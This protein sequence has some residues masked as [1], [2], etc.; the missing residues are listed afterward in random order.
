VSGHPGVQRIGDRLGFD[1]PHL[2]SSISIEL[3]HFAL[4][5]IELAEVLQRLLGELALVIRVQI[6]E[7][8]PRVRQTPAFEHAFGQDGFV[9]RVVVA[10]E[11]AT[12]GAEEGWACL[13]E[14]VSVTS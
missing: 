2:A 4:D 14:R 1:L 11:L 3:L 7:L 8:T 12:P 13:P 9:A 5:V 10:D 6:K